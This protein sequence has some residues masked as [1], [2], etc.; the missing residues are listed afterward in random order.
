MCASSCCDWKYGPSSGAIP[1]QSSAAMI[2]SVHSGRLRASSVSSIRR[3]NVPPRR[4]T[5][6]QLYSAAR[7]LPTWKYPV[8]EGAKRARGGEAGT[9]MR[10]GGAPP[11][12]TECG[13]SGPASVFLYGD[14][15]RGAPVDGLAQ[16]LP[17]LLGRMLVEDVEV[18]VVADLEDLGQDAH[19]HCVAG[20]LVEVND[21]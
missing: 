10:D 17:E 15:A 9:V 20:T 11:A 1:S 7:A 4:R 16:P 8:G 2:P 13:G 6:S 5:K 14:G 19:A 18:A 21:D 3:M 12:P